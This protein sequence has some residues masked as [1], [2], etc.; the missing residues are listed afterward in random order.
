[1]LADERGWLW[2]DELEG[3]L[4]AEREHLRLDDADGVM[5][6]TGEEAE[7]AAKEQERAAKER[8]WAKL[9][10]LGFNPEDLL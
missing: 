1:M 9:Q 7:R 3:W 2:S 5:R 4:A 8:A 6:L 10:E